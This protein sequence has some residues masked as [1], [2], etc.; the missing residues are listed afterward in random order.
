MVRT[1][2]V[3]SRIASQVSATV[4][5]TGLVAP[6][7]VTTMRSSL[8]GVIGGSAPCVQGVRGHGC[9][10]VSTA[11]GGRLS[12][13]YGGRLDACAGAWQPIGPPRTTADRQ[14]QTCAPAMKP[15][16]SR[17]VL[18]FLTSSSGMRTPN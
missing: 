12:A 5:P 13:A 14:G 8:L 11:Y 2:D 9:G 3:P 16:A 15:T 4:P 1:H 18:R 17:T 10:P 7:P 6:R